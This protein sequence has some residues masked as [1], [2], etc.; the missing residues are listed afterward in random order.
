MQVG[1][2]A[3]L[4]DIHSSLGIVEVAPLDPDMRGKCIP[5]SAGTFCIYLGVGDQLASTKGSAKILIN[6]LLGWVWSTEIRIISGHN[7][8][9][10]EAR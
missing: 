3:E 7:E 4:I 6:G 2:L 5:F 1:D 8:V 9:S 10:N